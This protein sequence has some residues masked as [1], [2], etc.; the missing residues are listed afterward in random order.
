M[1]DITGKTAI[2][3]GASSGIGRASALALAEEGVN[4]VLTA[5]SED[6][7]AGIAKQCRDLGVQA[8]YHAG[9]A[10][11]EATAAETVGLAVNTFG[12]I[13]ILLS[14]AGI[15]IAGPF[16]DSTM[17]TYDVQMDTNVR[18]SYAFCL[19]AVPELIKQEESQ[20]IIVSSV[21]GINGHA[22]E[23]A[24]S[25]TKF[26]NRGMAQAL[27]L[28]FR[29]QGLKVCTLCPSATN[30]EFQVGAGRTREENDARLMLLPQDVADAVVFVCRQ[31]QGT[32]RVME[33]TLAA[34]YGN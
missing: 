7:L 15:G 13:D 2:I 10:R 21:T 32:S 4:L 29:E 26:A 3:T 34:M 12:G 27:N 18:S 5:R 8:V 23:V 16:L 9:D 24:Y 14:N 25:A 28:E 33:M 19:H 30:T 20:L 17:E 1:Q 31:S 22:L 11:E 6:K